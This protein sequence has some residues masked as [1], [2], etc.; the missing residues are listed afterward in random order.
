MGKAYFYVVDR[1]LGFAPNPFHGICT[2]ATC[3]PKIRNV[4]VEDDWV[5]G[6]GGRRLKATGKCIFAMRVTSKTSYN[7]YWENPDYRNKKP[8]RNGSKMLQ[9]GDNVYYKD[10]QTGLWHQAHS[11][12]SLADGGIN[13][14]NLNRDTTSQYVLLSHHFYYFGKGAVLI[15]HNLLTAIGYTNHTGHN[16]YSLELVKPVIDWIEAAAKNQL[17]CTLDDPFEFEDS[18]THYSVHTNKMNR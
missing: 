3:K 17:N 8:V 14:Y 7:E 12:H 18:D 16:T 13:E 1:D 5:V 4:A 11:H 15:P 9:L 2:L 10:T 6:M